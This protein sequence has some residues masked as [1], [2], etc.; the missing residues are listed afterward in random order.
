MEITETARSVRKT[1]DFKT[2]PVAR[3]FSGPFKLATCQTEGPL[4][5]RRRGRHKADID[6]SAAQSN[7]AKCLWTAD[8]P[9]RG[10]SRFVIAR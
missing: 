7:A 6:K 5:I 2:T 10:R 8:G 3:P 1:K 4:N 9:A